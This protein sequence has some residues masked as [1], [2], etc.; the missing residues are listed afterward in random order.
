MIAM[1]P[2]EKRDFS[3]V[4]AL[5]EKLAALLPQRL[6]APMGIV[7]TRNR[8]RAPSPAMRGTIESWL[9]RVVHDLRS[10][11]RMSLLTR[12]ALAACAAIFAS[13]LSG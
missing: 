8:L 3:E 2:S 13:W 4:T 6:D 7:T 1:F 12:V 9:A 10:P 5:A 11:G